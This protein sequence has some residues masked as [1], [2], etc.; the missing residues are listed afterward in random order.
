MPLRQERQASG[1]HG[2]AWGRLATHGGTTGA[3][4]ASASCPVPDWIPA[5]LGR[6]LD[7]PLGRAGTGAVTTTAA[8]SDAPRGRL[9]AAGAGR[10]DAAVK[11]SRSYGAGQSIQEA[12]V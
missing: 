12:R 3:I 1:V 8:M 10:R 11:R 4:T 9:R 6:G 2:G 7:G 5:H